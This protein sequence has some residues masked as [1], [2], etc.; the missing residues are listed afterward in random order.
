MSTNENGFLFAPGELTLPP[1][2]L[3]H[4]HEHGGVAVLISRVILLLAKMSNHDKALSANYMLHVAISRLRAS[5]RTK[6]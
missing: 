5:R 4:G 6:A 3:H 1:E 2:V